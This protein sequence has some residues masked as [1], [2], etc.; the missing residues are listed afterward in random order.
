MPR[1]GRE[2]HGRIFGAYGIRHAERSK[3]ILENATGPLDTEDTIGRAKKIRRDL[4]ALKGIVTVKYKLRW[5][6]EYV[7][8]V[9]TLASI[10]MEHK[11][12]LLIFD[13]QPLM[14]HT[15]AIL[16]MI[17]AFQHQPEDLQDG[18]TAEETATMIHCMS[19][20]R[21][22][23]Y[24]IAEIFSDP[25]AH[26]DKAPF[27]TYNVWGDPVE[28]FYG[29]SNN[30]RADP[31]IWEEILL[32]AAFHFEEPEADEGEAR[33]K[34]L[35]GIKRRQPNFLAGSLGESTIRNAKQ[36]AAGEGD[37]RKVK[38]VIPY[39]KQSVINVPPPI[40]AVAVMRLTGD[41]GSKDIQPWKAEKM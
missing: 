21:V 40:A 33:G 8:S 23:A 4:G 41:Y 29:V 7:K 32:Q 5:D 28:E 10:S 25:R 30:E 1:S 27:R 34:P 35:R 39:F 24:L 37:C 26:G 13:T 15:K 6:N 3:S 22:L 9:H 2:D 11:E 36:V 38:T 17:T 18:G 14:T 20:L 31:Q 19:F 16:R 12:L